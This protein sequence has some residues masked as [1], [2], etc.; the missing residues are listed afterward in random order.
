MMNLSPEAMVAFAN[1]M[2]REEAEKAERERAC[3][4][5]MAK[6]RALLELPKMMSKSRGGQPPLE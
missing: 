6:F 2:V 1:Q 5:V 4:D 3:R